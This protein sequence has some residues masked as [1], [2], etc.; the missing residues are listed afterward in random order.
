MNKN[1]VNRVYNEAIYILKTK[2]TVREIA[3][4]FNVSKSTVHK[5]LQERH[6]DIDKNLHIKI[7][8]IFKDHIE[9][10]HIKGGEST[11]KR[12]LKL[13]EG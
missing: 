2:K 12:Y 5:D 1:I 7:V 11:R 13:K 10:R 3:K 9:I 6:Y 8:E 4:K